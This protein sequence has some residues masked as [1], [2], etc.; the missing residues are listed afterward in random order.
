MVQE[1]K[2]CGSPALFFIP[3][4]PPTSSRQYHHRWRRAPC[5][6]SRPS[7]TSQITSTSLPGRSPYNP[8]CKPLKG[9]V[10]ILIALIQSPRFNNLFDSLGLL[11]PFGFFGF[12]GFLKAICIDIWIDFP[13]IYLGKIQIILP[14]RDSKF[15]PKGVHP[16]KRKSPGSLK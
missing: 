14:I 10:V 1:V 8:Y 9:K 4:K 2:K 5:R 3:G 6:C 11:S 16:F 13:K 7:M 12:L 15:F